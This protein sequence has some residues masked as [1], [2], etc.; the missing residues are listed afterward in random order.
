MAKEEPRY[1]TKRIIEDGKIKWK[2]I[3]VTADDIIEEKSLEIKNLKA[4][5]D[6]LREQ[7]AYLEEEQQR[8]QLKSNPAMDSAESYQIYK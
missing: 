6:S 2:N 1:K 4:L 5:V 7:I 8:Q 3:E